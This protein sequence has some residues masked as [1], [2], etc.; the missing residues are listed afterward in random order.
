MK[1]VVSVSL[2]SSRRDSRLTRE[3]AGESFIVERIGTDGSKA[4]AIDLI[5]RLDGKVDAFG[6]GGTDL[7]IYAGERRFTFRESAEIAAAAKIT[8]I[9]DGSGIKNTLER[10][11]ISYLE[12]DRGFDFHNLPVLLVCGVDRFGL[13][14]ALVA[15]GAKVVFGDLLYGLGLPVPISR[16]STLAALARVVAPIITQMPIKWFY[17]VGEKQTQTTPRYTRYFDESAVIA[18]DF[19][20]IRRFMPPLLTGKIIL[21]NTVTEEDEQML[22]SAGAV[23]LVTSTPEMGGRSFGTN[24][25]EAIVVALAGRKPEDIS[26]EAYQEILDKLNIN[27]RVQ[28]LQS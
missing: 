14:D 12:K 1:R 10:R 27:P 16:I 9:V 23:T 4:K 3:F 21:T 6:L 8:P 19:H 20:F 7:Y 15:A 13:A 2:G 24:V 18:G 22:R 28:D 5:R 25:L 17:P 26:R 11:L